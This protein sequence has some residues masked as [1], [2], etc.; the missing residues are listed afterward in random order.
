MGVDSF[1]RNAR[2]H[3]GQETTRVVL[4]F[5]YETSRKERPIEREHTTGLAEWMKR[6]CAVLSEI[7]DEKF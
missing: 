6:F 1:A 7:L 3:W 4:E 2:D 5:S